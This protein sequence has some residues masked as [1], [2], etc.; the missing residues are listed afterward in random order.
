MTKNFKIGYLPLTKANWTNDT[1]ETARKKAKLFLQNLPGVKVVGGDRMIDFEDKA[2]AELDFFEKERPDLIVAHFMTFSLG[3]IVP[4]FAQR[5]KVPVV[6]WSM[7]EP[8][9]AGGRLQ[10][11]SFC[12]AN[13]NSHFLY[14]MHVPYFH[15]HAEVGSPQAD[16][17]LEKAI[18]VT[19]TNNVLQRMRIGVIGGRV[20]GF[21]TSSCDEMLLR[22]KIGPEVKFITEHEVIEAA[23]SLSAAELSEAKKTILSDAS[24]HPT[25]GPCGEQ[26]DKSA[27]LYAAVLKM[28]DK[29]LV[30]TFAMRC[31]PEFISSDLY[32]IAVC[33]TIG[34]LTNH[35]C[36]TACEGDAYGA[37]M[38]RIEQELTGK[39]PFFCD[40]IVM[41]GESGVAWHCGAAPCKLCKD[42][43]QPQLR[44]S[45]TIEG[46]GVKGVTDEFPLKPGRITLARLGETR[47]GE[48]FRMLIATGEGLDTD[49]FVR[50]NP[51]RIKFD[52]G[53]DKLREV[54]IEQGWEHHYALCYG[55]LVP[56]LL[57]LCRILEIEAVVVR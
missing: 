7:K 41:E 30:D 31:W 4:M 24:V 34:H 10:N 2:I 48:K 15:I 28:R 20:P 32:G 16:A 47:D 37:V 11:N 14:R 13:M 19:R 27:A 45:A 49:L 53:C 50:G 22:T 33:S 12:A 46:G 23:R 55:D 43:F 35:G 6:L 51:L 9:P 56:A 8:D 57:D 3:V 39:L 5:L 1:L 40:M 52:A 29:F 42:G 18:R 36:L 44:R 17:G 38:M 54:V 26:L 25:D 21:F